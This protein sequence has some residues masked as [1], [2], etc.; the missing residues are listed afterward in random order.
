M[1]HLEVRQLWVQALIRDGKLKF[2]KVPRNINAADTQTKHWMAEGLAHFARMSFMRP[3]VP[4]KT[5]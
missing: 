4:A 5:C 2:E 3:W 1:K